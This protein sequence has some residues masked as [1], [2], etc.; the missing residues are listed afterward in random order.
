MRV[1]D[2]GA[3]EVALSFSGLSCKVVNTCTFYFLSLINLVSS[4]LA[5][6]SHRLCMSRLVC[7][8]PTPSP[9]H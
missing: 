5:T 8:H 2:G 6:L 1:K 9:T 7:R 4:L 3:Q